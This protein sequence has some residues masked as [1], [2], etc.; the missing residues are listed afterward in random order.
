VCHNDFAKLRIGT[1]LFL[2]II[3]FTGSVSG[4]S[5]STP[6]LLD[7]AAVA[8]VQSAITAAGG[9]KSI[10]QALAIGFQ[11]Q[12]Q[13]DGSSNA[14]AGSALVVVSGS[15]FEFR[16]TTTTAGKSRVLAS[17]HGHPGFSLDGQHVRPI[18]DFVSAAALPYELPSVLLYVELNDPDLSIT[19]GPERAG[20]PRHVLIASTNP[21]ASV[22]AIRQKWYFS[23]STGLPD[24]VEYTV[25][26]VFD[27]FRA[28]NK[29]ISFESYVSISG[30]S[31]PSASDDF[32]EGQHIGRNKIVSMVINPQY[33]A[34]DCDLDVQGAH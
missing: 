32:L 31:L 28:I 27:G 26:T 4:Q 21:E 16:Y 10:A 7:P 2:S 34:S 11:S 5:S 8:I 13:R 22:Y 25:P 29:S 1:I 17:G 18:S 15:R 6:R 24:R 14:S 20:E 30:I 19:L 12:Y 3:G 33:Q 23:T 9:N